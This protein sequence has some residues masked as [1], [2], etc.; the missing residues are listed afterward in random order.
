MVTY[1]VYPYVAL[2]VF[3]TR[4]S[5]GRL[6]EEVIE[7]IE[8]HASIIQTCINTLERIVKEYFALNQNELSRLYNELNSLEKQGDEY[9]R[10]LMNTLKASHIHP[11]DR[12]DFLRLVFTMDE[13]LGLSK[14][15][16][17]KFLIFKHLDIAI[18]QSVHDQL[19][20][21][22]EK[23]VEA[24]N[25]VKKL[26]ESLRGEHVEIVELAHKVEELE[27]EVDDVRLNALEELYKVCLLGYS[28]V[29]IALPV[30]IDDAETITDKCEEIA[31]I[32]RL[33]L[34]SR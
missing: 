9:K 16:A 21:I 33:H 17:K 3:I 13:I 30:V 29:C 25:Y 12:E 31:D 26:I 32:Y 15:V 18:P 10:K 34:V 4:I 8:T 6:L 28:I 2:E 20:K 11:E 22:V 19:V 24:V 14:A 7:E 1:K 23:S 5:G 27:E